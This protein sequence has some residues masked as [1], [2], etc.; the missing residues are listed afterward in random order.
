MKTPKTNHWKTFAK[1]LFSAAVLYFLFRKCDWPVL[2]FIMKTADIFFITIAFVAVQI[3]HV[4]AAVRWNLLCKKTSFLL[5][6]KMIYVSRLYTTILPGQLF[7]EA[8]KV[9]H[10]RRASPNV[11]TQEITA[12]VIVDK[13]VG[14]VGLLLLGIYGVFLS[15][16]LQTGEMAMWFAICVLVL[17]VCLALPILPVASRLINFIL[18]AIAK[19]SDKMER[20]ASKL[21]LFLVSWQSYLRTPFV[22]LAAI[23]VGIA[24]QTGLAASMYY[25]GIAA[26]APVPFADWSWIFAILSVALLLPISF[27]GLGVRE[28]TLVGFLGIF[29]VSHELAL[30]ISL[31]ALF[32]QVLD[33]LIGGVILL[34]DRS[35]LKKP[36]LTNELDQESVS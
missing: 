10:V 29:A 19:H 6:L 14:L 24:V 18:D 15:N 30:S 8:A 16:K 9:F 13:I 17:C 36:V 3:A 20:I 7:G 5:L 25:L 27:A 1:L 4:I 32:I 26:S 35:M 2:L 33:A 11:T 31:L 21:R 23:F 22:L 34:S 12:S 28:T